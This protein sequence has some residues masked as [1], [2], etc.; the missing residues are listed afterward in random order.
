MASQTSPVLTALD[1]KGDLILRFGADLV[2]PEDKNKKNTK[3]KNKKDATVSAQEDLRVCSAT[4][5]RSSPVWAKMLFGPLKEGVRPVDGNDWIVDFPDEP[6]ILKNLLAIAHCRF[7]MVLQLQN[8]Q[9][10]LDDILLLNEIICLADKYL[11]IHILAPCSNH[12]LQA[13]QR[14]DLFEKGEMKL[15]NKH[16]M[17]YTSLVWTLGAAN[18]YNRSIRC[19]TIRLSRVGTDG[20]PLDAMVRKLFNLPRFGTPGIIGTKHT[21]PHEGKSPANSFSDQ[22]KRNREFLIKRTLEFYWQTLKERFNPQM[23]TGNSGHFNP[24]NPLMGVGNRNRNRETCC[25]ISSSAD[26]DEARKCDALVTGTN[27]A[28][29]LQS[30]QTR[31]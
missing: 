18:L 25:Q 12:W 13:L 21:L 26:A 24:F 7:D 14:S 16:L 5:R 8:V 11:M 1:E 10:A 19:S 2:I 15:D 27:L 20:E 23:G 6:A 28:A 22:I 9:P 31:T 29:N 4:M 3:N 30:T 17:E